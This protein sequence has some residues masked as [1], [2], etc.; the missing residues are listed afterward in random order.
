MGRGQEA[1]HWAGDRC[2]QGGCGGLLAS[3]H[4]WLVIGYAC[5]LAYFPIGS[6]GAFYLG[7]VAQTWEPIL[8]ARTLFLVS[9][10]TIILLWMLRREDGFSTSR[11]LLAQRVSFVASVASFALLFGMSH[12]FPGAQAAAL[13]AIAL[14]ASTATPKLGWYEAFLAVYESE[15]R[16]RCVI[17]ISACFLV[18]AVP[19]VAV[20]TFA[21]GP[22]AM[23]AVLIVLAL[24]S[25][26]CFEL[27]V[28]G[29]QVGA[30]GASSVGEPRR[31][32]YHTTLYTLVVLASFGISWGMTF[33]LTINLGYGDSSTLLTIGVMLAGI[34]VSAAIMFVFARLGIIEGTRFGMLLRVAIV[35]VGVSW[36]LMPFLCERAPAA[37]CF[38]CSLVY[39]VQSTIMILFIDEMCTDY[40]FTISVVTG[41]HY[42]LF[43]L[44]AVV[45]A[46]LFWAFF[47][48]NDTL[49]AVM[50][51]SAVCIIAS[52]LTIPF[53]PSRDSKA[54]AFA[55]DRLPNDGVYEDAL[56]ATERSISVRANLSPREEQVLALIVEGLS[57]EQIAEEL[58]L[59]VFTVKNH[60]SNIY[61]KVGVHSHN[62][63][64]SLVYGASGRGVNAGD[65]E[66]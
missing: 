48:A 27:V 41:V 2:K 57:R 66:E 46:L 29:M 28:R 56:V 12:L 37:G 58:S 38:V 9:T 32:S 15:G 43:V 44:S 39:I 17:V 24:G 6:L 51:V 49:T 14:G 7:N 50:L 16:S 21:E 13:F 47:S 60:T 18:A 52:L 19:I 33:S 31:T 30:D 53:L 35:A 4:L 40:H 25:W 64:V 36:A 63:L 20:P 65:E 23:Y 62:E 55:M 26:L 45:G 61:A 5:Y 59:S 8:L 10:V 3:W 22:L 42:G 34:G 11:H 54:S 1:S